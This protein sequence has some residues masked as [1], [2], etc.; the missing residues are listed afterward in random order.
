L[1]KCDEMGLNKIVVYIHRSFH[2]I[3]LLQGHRGTTL[4]L[5]RLLEPQPQFRIGQS[6]TLLVPAGLVRLKLISSQQ[7]E[8]G[9]R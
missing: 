2:T 3:A 5:Q 1:A 8:V 6:E 9:Q 7:E 4:E